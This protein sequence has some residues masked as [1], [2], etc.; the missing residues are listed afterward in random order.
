MKKKTLKTDIII[1]VVLALL[2]A[3]AVWH[4]SSGDPSGGGQ[5]T[6]FK[7]SSYTDYIGKRVG[8]LTGSSFEATTLE[9]LPDSQ[10]FYYDTLSDLTLALLNNK[11]D[12]FAEDE[13]VLR[14][15]S[16][17]HKELSY[18]K[19]LLKE[20]M[21]SFGFSKSGEKSD[22]LFKEFNEMMSELSADG[23]LENIIDKWFSQDAEKEVI[24]T[25]GLTGE[26]GNIN[27]SVVPTNVPFSMVTDG[28]L[29][30]YAVELT[31]MFCRKYGYTCTYEATNISSAIAGLTTG[32]YDM[33]ANNMTVTPERQ[34]SVRFSTPIYMGGIALAV[35]ADELAGSDGVTEDTPISYF[36]DKRIG[37]LT[38][39]T[40]EPI[41]NEILPNAQYV[42]FDVS[43]DLAL[44]TV[45]NKIDGY[46]VSQDQGETMLAENPELIRLKE[47]AGQSPYAFAFPKTEKGEA[48]RDKINEYLAKIVADGTMDRLIEKW[49][50]GPPEQHIDMTGFTGENGTISIACD[51]TTVPW[52]YIY[53]DQ[54][55]GYETELI[56]MFCREYGYTPEFDTMTFSAVIP[57]IASEKYDMAAANLTITE[58]RAESVFFSDKESGSDV[59]F[60][61][62]G[63]DL[64][65]QGDKGASQSFWD[66]I[67]L[68]FEKNF[69]REDRWKLILE[70]IVTTLIITVLSTV[71]GTVLAFLI[72]M[73]RRTG[74][75]LA[76]VISNIYVKLL[77]GTPMVVLLMILYY[78]VLGKSGLSA[79]WVAIIGFS[80]N[81]GAYASEI[82]RSGIESIDG[83]QRE[84]ALALG[85]SES[86]AFFRFIFPQAAVRFLPV[87][88]QEVV[89]LLK[90]T[91]IVGY[92]AIQDL[93]K[94]GDIIRSR[95]YEA[96]FPLIATAVI[97]FIL[98][99]II[100]MLLKI[101]LNSIK[102]KRKKGAAK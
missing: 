60:I 93:T 49:T 20:E 74:S 9:C 55:T 76:N 54:L 71:F 66:T 87:Y 94:M 97:Y 30:G 47:K 39:S 90:N 3:L 2:I 35:R 29:T 14:F 78:V 96:F 79:V 81:F 13:P 27:V 19:K 45:T 34:E 89:S 7:A 46:L 44:A 31:T 77:Q 101:I 57:A 56:T 18:F 5:D 21:Y 75:R 63:T 36:E 86:Q 8:I 84:A 102:P 16:N 38:G 41:A 64:S 83:G 61:T 95:T 99:W 51:G 91:S 53:E 15:V 92:I 48:L 10:Y 40:Y 52:E 72:C 98:A 4:F 50:N 42:Y 24:D 65:A 28:E 80:L 6:S 12:C 82:M 32:I 43:A 22:R 69:I 70:G 68:S 67:V 62:K 88:V 25:S 85:Y 26:N 73:F 37:I 58:E 17:E 33:C 23:T 59:I 100:S 1:I 11:I